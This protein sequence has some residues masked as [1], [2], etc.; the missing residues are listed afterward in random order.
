MAAN[1]GL[2]PTRQFALHIFGRQ[3]PVRKQGENE[4][5]T[6]ICTFLPSCKTIHSQMANDLL[7]SRSVLDSGPRRIFQASP[8]C[9]EPR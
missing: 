8:L 6:A 2:A 7:M 4:L 9:L 1:R 5:A 3:V